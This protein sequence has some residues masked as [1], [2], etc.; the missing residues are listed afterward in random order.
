MEDSL[1]LIRQ[2]A[3]NS[4]TRTDWR[5]AK[6]ANPSPPA[7]S[8][9]IEAAEESLDFA[10]PAF[11]KRCY[12]TI[13]NGGFGPGV[14][15]IGVPGGATD[16]HG[17]SIVDLYDTF[18][19]SNPDDE[20]WQWPDRVV[21]ICHWSGAIYSCV[22]CSAP[23]GAVVCIDLSEYRPGHDLKRAMTPQSPSIEAWLRAWAEGVDLWQE[24]FPLDLE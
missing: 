22:D 1:Q 5:P 3:E 14:G 16:A 6:D 24:M 13:G 19:A 8:E 4:A 2:R 10:L 23:E 11:L 20:A 12:A 21:P 9:Q 17:S 15:L 18:S 7:T